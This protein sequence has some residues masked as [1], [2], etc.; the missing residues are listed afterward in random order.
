MKKLLTS[1]RAC[2]VAA[3]IAVSM[4][5]GAQF[6]GAPVA[7]AWIG[8]PLQVTV[9]ARFASPDADDACVQADVLYGDMRVAPQRL[10]A[11]AK[12]I[13]IAV[14]TIQGIAVPMVAGCGQDCASR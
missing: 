11:M 8:Q 13:Q 6:L 14:M 5:A 4:C 7:E 2:A 1:G 10:S 9:P 3:L 12:I